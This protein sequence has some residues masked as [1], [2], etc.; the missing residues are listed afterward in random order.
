MNSFN[1]FAFGAVAEWV[2]RNLVG[3][4]P[5]EAH[6]GYKRFTIKPRLSEGLTWVKGSYES[7][8]GTIE[9]DWGIEPE[10]FHLNLTVPPNSTATVYLPTDEP[11]SLLENGLP[12]SR[13][14]GVKLIRVEDEYA[15]L[16]VTS[17]TY[18]FTTSK[19]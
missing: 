8:Y 10:R 19:K 2:W 12:V 6:P 3:L 1:H 17:G 7:I 5:D 4:N 14:Q 13:S 16:E 18:A 15:V 9:C 11:G